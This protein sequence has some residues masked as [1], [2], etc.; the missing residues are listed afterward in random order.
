MTKG[1]KTRRLGVVLIGIAAAVVLGILAL[2]RFVDVNRYKPGLEAA[3]SRATGLDV[4]IGGPM[5]VVFFP[6][7]GLSVSD[8][9]VGRGGHDVLKIEEATAG[10]RLFPLLWGAA[11][12]RTLEI[13]RPELVVRRTGRG[14]FDWDRYVSGPLRKARQ[15]LPGAFDRIERVTVSAGSV[16]YAAA[17]SRSASGAH[18]ISLALRQVAF[19][20]AAADPLRTVSF[21]GV[22]KAASATLDGVEVT[23]ITFSVQA[24]DGNYKLAPVGF[25]V[26]GGPG[27]ASGWLS[28]TEKTPLGHITVSLPAA[29]AGELAEAGGG[30]R[31]PLAGTLAFSASLFAKGNGPEV[32]AR[33]LT[34]D[35]SW[36]GSNLDVRGFDPDA[37]LSGAPRNG[38]AM[39]RVAALLL[40]GPPFWGAARGLAGLF[41]V[42]AESAAQGRVETLVSS[43]T[44]KDGVFTA[45]DVALAT[46]TGR[47][48]LAGGVDVARRRFDGLTAAVVD[49]SGCAAAKAAIDG[50][51]RQPRIAKPPPAAGRTCP[52]GAS[53]P[54]PG[55]PAPGTGCEAFYAGAVPAPH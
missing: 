52:R 44:A 25:T 19:P 4:R 8:V 11:R 3:A 15:A 14:P 47:I 54:Q 21:Q 9:R 1:R 31:G 17:R 13:T 28:V 12:L 26:F 50:P 6:P 24:K 23:G 18:D 20:E 37:L 2:W 42:P 40:P 51:F 32:M 38:R 41:A 39:V 30:E 27:D 7:F 10:L 45:K 36:K 49:A 33:T 48:A 35:V 5:Q 22:G 34:G 16:S 46:K 29:R 53:M 43:W 55:K